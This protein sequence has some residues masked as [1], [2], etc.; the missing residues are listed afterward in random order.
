MIYI[1]I[2]IYIQLTTQQDKE[3]SSTS[4]V[5]TISLSSLNE[6]CASAASTDI[7]I[8]PSTSYIES[9]GKPKSNR[10]ANNKISIL[11]LAEASGIRTY[12]L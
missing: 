2:Y 12:S 7:D 5:L 8:I 3:L 11:I 4:Y 1:Y 9:R 6:S 10:G